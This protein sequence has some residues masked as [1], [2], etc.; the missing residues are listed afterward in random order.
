MWIPLALAGLPAWLLLA[1]PGGP[2]AVPPSGT[3]ATEAERLESAA[4][5]RFLEQERRLLQVGERIRI[6]G[7]DLCGDK[8]SPVLGILAATEEEM[9]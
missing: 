3:V 7:L 9:P 8:R 2:G 1:Q 5:A 4:W 6:H